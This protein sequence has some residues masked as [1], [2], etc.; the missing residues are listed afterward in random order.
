MP[1]TP[2]FERRHRGLSQ[3]IA[4]L[5]KLMAADLM[6]DRAPS[7]QNHLTVSDTIAHITAAAVY[8]F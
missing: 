6:S 4:M 7:Q 5:T 1:P 8:A 3:S 2:R